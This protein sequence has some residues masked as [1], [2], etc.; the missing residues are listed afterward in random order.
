[1]RRLLHAQDTISCEQL[2]RGLVVEHIVYLLRGRTGGLRCGDGTA[3]SSP[4][5]S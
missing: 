5:L 3:Q 1:M 2:V 4:P